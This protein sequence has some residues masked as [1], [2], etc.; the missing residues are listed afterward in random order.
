MRLQNP[1]QQQPER[2]S[3]QRMLFDFSLAEPLSVGE[4]VSSKKTA[5]TFN[6]GYLPFASQHQSKIYQQQLRLNPK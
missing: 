1:S 3:R 4:Q 5:T 6:Y 2:V